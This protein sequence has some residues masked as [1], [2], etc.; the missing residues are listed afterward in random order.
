MTV[1]REVRGGNHSV[2]WPDA[3][4]AGV[5]MFLV[6][7][8]GG[9]GLGLALVHVLGLL[10]LPVDTDTATILRTVVTAWSP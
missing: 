3:L 9:L 4:G 7:T 1:V 8:G 5:L 2:A 10:G 6:I